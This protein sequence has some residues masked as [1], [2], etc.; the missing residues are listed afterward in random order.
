M[1]LL[2]PAAS[3]SGSTAPVKIVTLGTMA[4]L[5]VNYHRRAL[6]HAA[7]VTGAAQGRRGQRRI[8]APREPIDP[9]KALHRLAIVWLALSLHRATDVKRARIHRRQL[10]ATSGIFVQAAVRAR[11]NAPH[12]Q[13]AP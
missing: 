4:L 3:G 1:L 9:V 11:F 6:V 2:T 5:L 12:K 13:H 7:L 8:L 10:C